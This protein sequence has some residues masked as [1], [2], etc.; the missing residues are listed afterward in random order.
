MTE[1][2]GPMVADVAKPTLLAL[3]VSAVVVA[4]V[5]AVVRPT[6]WWS[7]YGSALFA[8]ALATGLT[9]PLLASSLRLP[10]TLAMPRVLA[11]GMARAMVT[12]GVAGAAVFL[13]HVPLRATMLTAMALYASVLAAETWS[14]SH[15]VATQATPPSTPSP[16]D[17][18]A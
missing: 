4:G 18:A 16:S 15:F 6:G 8:A 14:A 10:P 17:D 7:A 11:V 12:L 9:L 3:G 2:A 5:G 13:L 1:P